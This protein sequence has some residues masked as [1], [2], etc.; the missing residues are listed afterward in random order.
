MQV[1][2]LARIAGLEQYP[3]TFRANLIH[4]VY[5][6]SWKDYL[7]VEGDGGW[8]SFVYHGLTHESVIKDRLSGIV[9]ICSGGWHDIKF[10]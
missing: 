7:I 1:C 3:F 10:Y 5:F 9:S 4:P 6:D 2:R 8:R